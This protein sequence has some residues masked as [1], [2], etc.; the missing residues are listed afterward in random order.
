[1]FRSGPMVIGGPRM[2]P[3]FASAGPL[4]CCNDR[5]AS[6]ALRRTPRRSPMSATATFDTAIPAARSDTQSSRG[7][8]V[9]VK[10]LAKSFS[11]LTVLDHVD[12]T[13]GSGEFVTLLGP[14]GSGKTTLLM[15]LAG[16]T[17]PD[18]GHISL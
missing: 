18:A 3:P 9:E 2:A 12:L 16:F 6:G 15:A 5:P 13:I 14:S 10:G 8:T 7:M 1:R 17:D 4:L 11:K